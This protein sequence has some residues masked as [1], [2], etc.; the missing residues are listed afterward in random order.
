MADSSEPREMGSGT[1]GRPGVAYDPEKVG[2]PGQRGVPM[3]DQHP[4]NEGDGTKNIAADVHI[5]GPYPSDQD[6]STSHSDEA[7]PTKES[8]GVG[9][10]GDVVRGTSTSTLRE[11]SEGS[12]DDTVVDDEPD[13]VRED[14]DMGTGRAKGQ[15]L[16]P[17]SVG[18]GH[19][20]PQTPAT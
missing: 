11:E 15:G 7:P 1:S 4:T 12:A 3:G 2:E 20:T 16:P 13:P 19:D 9:S 8:R 18:P 5:P 14:A 10:I 17:G 6:E